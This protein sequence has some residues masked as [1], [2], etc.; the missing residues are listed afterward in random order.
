MAAGKLNV[1]DALK[2]VSSRQ[3]A[4][5]KAFERVTGLIGAQ[6]DDIHVGLLA[7]VIANSAFGS[8]GKFKPSDFIPKW[9]SVEPEMDEEEK[10][11]MLYAKWLEIVASIEESPQPGEVFLKPR[12]E[13]GQG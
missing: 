4:E 5:W 3:I 10:A 11:E 6:R 2:D 1:D 7:S 13:G 12:E 9:D 8:K